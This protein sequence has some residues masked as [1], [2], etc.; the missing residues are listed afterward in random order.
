MEE[1]RTFAQQEVDNYNLIIDDTNPIH[2]DEEFCAKTIF[3]API[4]PGLLT[5]SLFGGLLGSN[6]PDGAILLNITL[7][8]IAPV[9]VGEKV[10]VTVEHKSQREDK[11]IATY[12][13]TCYK[14]DGRTAI[15]GE[16]IIRL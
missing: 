3:K 9:Y 14:D 10:R 16:A 4:V 13:L 2:Y 8:F 6:L 1:Y 15:R 7:G 11:P 5:S 12:K